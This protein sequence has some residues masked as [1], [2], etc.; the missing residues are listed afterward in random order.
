MALPQ[1][2]F[3]ILILL[4]MQSCSPKAPAATTAEGTAGT[5]VT[6]TSPGTGDMQD[7]ITLNA[8]SSFLLKTAVKSSANGYLQKVNTQP[9]RF[10]SKGQDLFVIRTKESQ[11]LGNT[12]STLDSSLHFSGLI[13]IKSPGSGYITG[14]AYQTGDYVQDGEQLAIISDS[15]SFIFLLNLP[16]ELKPFIPS[17]KQLMLKLPDSTM[18]TGHLG[19]AMPILDSVSQTQSYQISVNTTLDIPENLIAK[20]TLVRKTKSHVVTLP[21][22]AVLSDEMQSTF[23]IMKMTNSSTAV[24]TFVT[25]GMENSTSVEILTPVLS[26]SDK[27]VLTGNY[28][29]PDTAK[30]SI[31]K[32]P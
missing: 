6:I 16:Y 1:F 29:L 30:V 22:A 24:K 2:T 13:H 4:A 7:V 15:K 19:V 21:K 17:N 27:I 25:K 12:I 14:L 18:L 10:V 28:G 26:A 3:A 31:I 8:V 9:G 20:V 32:Q 11:S 5:P 23:W